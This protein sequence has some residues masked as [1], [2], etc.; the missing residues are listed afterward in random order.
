MKKTLALSLLTVAFLSQSN[1]STSVSLKPLIVSSSAIKTDELASTQAVEVY[2]AKDIEDSHAQNLYDFFNTHT[3]VVT[4]PAYG[5]SFTQKIDFRGFGIGDGYQNIVVTINGRRINNIDMVAPLLSAIAPESIERIEIIKSSGV[6]N[7]GDGANAGVINIITKR[8]DAKSITLYG[9]NYAKSGAAATFAHQ[10]DTYSLNLSAETQK[11][12]GIRTIDA[13]GN[14]DKNQFSRGNFSLYFT[15]NSDLEL[16]L[17]AD[18]AR[19]DFIY[20]SYLTKAE[21]DDN[22]MQAGASNWGAAHQKY[23]TDSVNAGATYYANDKLSFKADIAREKKKSNFITY[24]SISHYQYDSVKISSEYVSDLLE[25][26]GGVDLFNGKRASGV[27]ETSKNNLA[28]FAAA[29]LRLGS[30]TLNA[31]ARG[32]KITYKHQDTTT[33]LKSDKQ[34]FGAELGY[35]YTLDKTNSLFLNYAHS[36]EAPD[37]DRFFV[38]TY[39]APTYTATVNFNGFIEPAIADSWTLGYNSIT[40]SNKLKASAYY[41]SLKNEIYYYAGVNYV[42]AKNTNINKSHK[43]GFDFYDKMILSSDFDFTFNYNYVQAIIDN[44]KEN[45]ED[46]SGKKLPG[47]SDHNVKATLAYHPNSNAVI[48]LTQVWRSE[49]YAANDFANSL[50]QKQEAY[51]STDITASYAKDNYEVFAKITNLFN[52]KNGLWIQDDA[53]YPVNFTTTAFAG[54][55]IKY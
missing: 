2:T 43:Y 39:P 28:V 31:G 40:S 30:H 22:I 23:D 47:V 44:E 45:G 48:S 17:G 6:V 32:E 46:F 21:Y 15:P 24:S 35:N 52:Q 25:I 26:N 1:A 34:L 13:A 41:I 7:G 42:G 36:Y 3:S 29:S 50:S 19:E 16:R 10:E 49:A 20:A 9:G 4:M 37:I 12:G 55:K 27:K 8:G 51:K 18:F 38:T 11:N 33:D 54:V 14:K 53:I 5:N